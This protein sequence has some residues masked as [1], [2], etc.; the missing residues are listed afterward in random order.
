MHSPESIAHEI[1]IPFTK[2]KYGNG[3]IIF[4]IWHIDPEK[5]GTDDSCGRFIRARHANQEV[6]KKIESEFD[7]NYKHNYWFDANGKQLFSTSGI[8]LMM[9]KSA[10]WIHFKHDRKKS[11]AFFKKYLHEILYFAENPIDCGGDSITNKW[12]DPKFESRMGSM[13][14]MVYTDILRKERPWYRHP[15]W[16]VHHWRIQIPAFQRLKRRFWDKCSVCN[17]RGFK[18]SA[19]SDWGGKRIWHQGC[20]ISP[21]QQQRHEKL[22][23]LVK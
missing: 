8:L 18:S 12:N 13:A 1:C 20:D 4:T 17:K 7:F 14:S 11:D 2:D 19:M 23:K 6:L 22:E 15:K 5:D 21:Q 16:H 9:Y 10:A 3:I